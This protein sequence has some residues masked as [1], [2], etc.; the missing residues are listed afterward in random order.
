MAAWQEVT[1]V[2]PELGKIV[3]HCPQ[4]SVAGRTAVLQSIFLAEEGH[5]CLVDLCIRDER[6]LCHQGVLE[7]LLQGLVATYGVFHLVSSRKERFFSECLP[8]AA[9]RLAMSRRLFRHTWSLV[10]SME[11]VASD[12]SPLPLFHVQPSIL[13][14]FHLVAIQRFQRPEADVCAV[15]RGLHHAMSFRARRE[16]IPWGVQAPHLRF[17]RSKSHLHKKGADCQKGCLRNHVIR[18]GTSHVAWKGHQNN[19]ST[20]NLMW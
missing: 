14:G 11:V 10:S 20:R 19:Y 2:L 4:Q 15:G 13:Q 8:I 17:P 6:I 12:L 16:Q 3:A 7:K 9:V 5:E 18:A 1:S